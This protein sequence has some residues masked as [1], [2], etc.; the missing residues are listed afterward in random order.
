M[1]M[2]YRWVVLS[3]VGAL[4]GLPIAAAA[5]STP[6]TWS[7]LIGT[8]MDVSLRAEAEPQYNES[9]G[10]IEYLDASDPYPQLTVGKTLV[11]QP[12]SVWFRTLT[13]AYDGD[14]LSCVTKYRGYLLGDTLFQQT[15]IEKNSYVGKKIL[16]RRQNELALFLPQNFQAIYERRTAAAGS[17][18]GYI[19]P[20][21]SQVTRGVLAALI[22]IWVAE[23]GGRKIEGDSSLIREA[24]TI[25][26]SRT[27]IQTKTWRDG[28]DT[29]SCTTRSS[30]KWEFTAGDTLV[31][32][33]DNRARQWKLLLQGSNL[34]RW[35]EY[36]KR[37]D[38]SRPMRVYRR[39]VSSP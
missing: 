37:R 3:L 34:I 36:H 38:P 19:A 23:D 5:Q 28:A 30:W 31:I 14:T 35:A 15:W 25:R 22:G 32:S 2:P 21:S 10:Q 17:V 7:N 6:A 16:L 24:L 33:D 1:Q 29:F 27:F 39:M 13:M 8:W 26:P 11:F 20:A 18:H 12:D 4:A 9:T